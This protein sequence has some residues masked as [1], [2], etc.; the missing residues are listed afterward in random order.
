MQ[1]NDEE[2]VN[3]M[4]NSDNAVLQKQ[5]RNLE[6]R[7]EESY[8][9]QHNLENL[10]EEYEVNMKRSEENFKLTNKK[11]NDLQKKFGTLKQ[12]NS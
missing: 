12:E 1:Q 4:G 9:S 6:E 2:F 11:Y 3:T 7:L 10:L 5:I 8:R